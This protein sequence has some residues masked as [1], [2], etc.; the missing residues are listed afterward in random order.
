MGTLSIFLC[1]EILGGMHDSMAFPQFLW[2][3]E[4]DRMEKRRK[5]RA[6]RAENGWNR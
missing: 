2:R 3:A 1:T 4:H 6:F 5:N